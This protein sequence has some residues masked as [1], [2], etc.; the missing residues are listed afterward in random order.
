APSSP[1]V[2]SGLSA[3]DAAARIIGR[4]AI[5]PS[6]RVPLDAA[7]GSVL[8][9]PVVSQLDVPFWTNSAMDGY[10][11]RAA[12]VRGATRGGP[13]RLDVIEPIPAGTTPTRTLGPGQA[14]RIFTGA[15]VPPGAD[16]VIRQEDTDEGDPIVL[17]HSDRDCDANL[18]FA[19]EDIRT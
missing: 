3:G 7:L 12:H 8:A 5:Q 11:A 2:A 14:A 18:R 16:S 15:P 1:D 17:I 10:A 13:E 4:V 9:E 19:G 6:L